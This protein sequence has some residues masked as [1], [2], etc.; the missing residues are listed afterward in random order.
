MPNCLTLSVTNSKINQA[1]LSGPG[2]NWTVSTVACHI[3]LKQ[4][5]PESEYKYAEGE[6]KVLEENDY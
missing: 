4:L 6:T 2:I 5:F 1:Q 3:T